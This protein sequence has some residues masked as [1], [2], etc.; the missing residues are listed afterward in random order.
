MWCCVECEVDRTNE[1][2][3]FLYT[4]SSCHECVLIL[5][6]SLSSL[7]FLSLPF[8]RGAH[9]CILNP[10]RFISVVIR[11]RFNVRWQARGMFP[12]FPQRLDGSREVENCRISSIALNFCV[13]WYYCLLVF[14]IFYVLRR[15]EG[16][17]VRMAGETF[18]S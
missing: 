4:C 17:A 9:C 14:L 3:S 8:L 11:L 1:A 12:P 5:R 18:R 10:Q 13:I 2:A 6:S 15:T 7:P 16:T